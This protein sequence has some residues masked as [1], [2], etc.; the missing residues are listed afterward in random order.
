VLEIA[1]FVAI[2]LGQRVAGPRQAQGVTPGEAERQGNMLTDLGIKKLPLPE[3]RKEIADGKV[4]WS[5]NRAVA[6]C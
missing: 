2:C 6:S 3:R 4:A 5:F 1:W